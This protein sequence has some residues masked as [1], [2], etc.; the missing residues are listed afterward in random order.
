MT[1]LGTRTPTRPNDARDKAVRRTLNQ[2]RS[3]TLDAFIARKVTDRGEEILY[4][5]YL[6]ALLDAIEGW[7]E[8]RATVHC[9]LRRWFD[10]AL[11]DPSVPGYVLSLAAV[12]GLESLRAVYWRPGSTFT[13]E[14]PE[15]AARV[16]L[17][18]AE[19]G[20]HFSSQFLDLVVSA[21]RRARCGIG[22]ATAQLKVYHRNIKRADFVPLASDV[23]VAAL[24]ALDYD[25]DTRDME[26]LDKM[27]R[28]VADVIRLVGPGVSRETVRDVLALGGYDAA[29]ALRSRG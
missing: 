2:R 4:E 19:A 13:F 14:S 7:R 1:H 8:P 20:R 9:T 18:R 29:L 24:R 10:A 15:E 17:V 12:G 25:D 6:A 5:P 11:R 3:N 27:T 23:A 21:H 16:G 22:L 26:R 28:Q